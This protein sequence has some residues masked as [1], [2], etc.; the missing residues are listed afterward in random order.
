MLALESFDH[1]VDAYRL[2]CAL[3]D[4]AAQLAALRGGYV[5]VWR[6]H[7]RSMLSAYDLNFVDG[8]GINDP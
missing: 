2:C 5:L 7:E 4:C 3:G 1:C 6:L 8:S